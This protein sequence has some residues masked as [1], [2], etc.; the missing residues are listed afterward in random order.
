MRSKSRRLQIR[1]LPNC[2][3]F[4]LASRSQHQS[5]EWLNAWMACAVLAAT[6]DP[7]GSGRSPLLRRP[8]LSCLLDMQDADWEQRL[9]QSCGRRSMT[10]PPMLS[11]GRWKNSPDERPTDDPVALFERGSALDSTGHPGPAVERYRR[12]LQLG[13]SGQRR[14][15]ATIQLASSLRNLGQADE[16]VALLT[17]ELDA[18]SDDLDD[19]VRAFL[20]LALT[21]VGREREAVSVALTALAPHLTRYNRSLGAYARRTRLSGGGHLPGPRR[22]RVICAAGN[23]VRV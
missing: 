13:L 5:P 10:N 16:S 14:R 15:R 4:A 18:G 7:T 12:A 19:A 9:T 8:G 6:A 2:G 1:T 23:V 21:S 3:C 17:A 11:W 22:L 20:A